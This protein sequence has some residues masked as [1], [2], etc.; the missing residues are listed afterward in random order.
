MKPYNTHTEKID[1]TYHSVSKHFYLRYDKSGSLRVRKSDEK[2][3]YVHEA[4]VFR[5]VF[6]TKIFNYCLN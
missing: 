6:T 3:N 5:N 2:A 4:F 1:R